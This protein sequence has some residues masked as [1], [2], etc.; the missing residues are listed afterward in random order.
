[1]EEEIFWVEMGSERNLNGIMVKIILP[2]IA[3]PSAWLHIY[4]GKL[5]NLSS[6]QCLPTLVLY[7]G[8]LRLVE[9]QDLV[10][11]FSF[12]LLHINFYTHTEKIKCR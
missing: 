3:A 8:S 6:G 1:V 5:T 9:M 11:I 7:R 2:L 10:E 12:S 4:S